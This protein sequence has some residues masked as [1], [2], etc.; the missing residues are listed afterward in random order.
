MWMFDDRA[1][2]QGEGG[3]VTFERLLIGRKG[4]P[5][6]HFLSVWKVGHHSSERAMEQGIWVVAKPYK[7]QRL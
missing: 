6:A 5:R 3:A 2:D 4:E 1:H 7:C